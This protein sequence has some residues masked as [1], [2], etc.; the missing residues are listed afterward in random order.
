M[1]AVYIVFLQFQFV[2]ELKDQVAGWWQF[3]LLKPKVKMKEDKD[4]QTNRPTR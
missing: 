1:C 4:R 3:T 2:E